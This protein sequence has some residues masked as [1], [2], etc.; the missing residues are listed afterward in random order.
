MKKRR[1]QKRGNQRLAPKKARA[2]RRGPV[3]PNTAVGQTPIATARKLEK[4]GDVAGAVRICETFLASNPR[5]V[6]TLRELASFKFRLESY[7]EAASLLLRAD[8]LDPA[9]PSRLLDL[10][11]TLRLAGRLEEADRFG[12][13]T[14]KAA[15]EN[16]EAHY[17][18]G[19]IRSILG[20]AEEARAAFAACVAADPSHMKARWA[21][22]WN[23][24][25]VYRTSEETD[26]W[27]RRTVDAIDDLT[28]HFD[29]LAA[30]AVE[31]AV[32]AIGTIFLL[33]YHERDDRE[34]Q[35]AYGSLVSRV[36]YA[37][38]GDRALPPE[39]P[40]APRRKRDRI[41]IGYASEHLS[42][43]HTISLLFGGWVL[44]A[45]RDRFEIYV[46]HLGQKVQRNT[47]ILARK[48]DV[49][50]HLNGSVASKIDAIREDD[51]D[52]LVYPDIG[53]AIDSFR[54]A[55]LRLAPVQCVSW[56]HP[57]TTGFPTMDYFLSSD[58]MEPA[59]AEAHYSEQLVRLPNLSI[60]YNPVRAEAASQQEKIGRDRFGIPEE[61][62]AFLCSQAPQKYLPR[63]DDIF[64][65]LAD[66][67]PNCKF[68]FIRNQ[69]AASANERFRDRLYA[70]FQ[71]NGQNPDDY[72][73]FLPWVPWQ[74]FLALNNVCDVFLDS[75][76]WSGGNT[77]LEALA[78]GL[79]AVTLPGGFM[80]GRHTY[81]ML[82]RL[83]AE[84]CIAESVDDYIDIAARL[85][86]DEAFRNRQ[87]DLI[88]SGAR[89]LYHDRSAIE[90][91]EAFYR[92]LFAEPAM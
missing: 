5:N 59:G 75:V 9:D 54:L 40:A 8:R 23:L 6:N 61:A 29:P 86:L 28:A 89:S 62:V 36:M 43:A 48:C 82:K 80:R 21:Q 2:G 39:R 57:V 73:H 46:Y 58:L 10:T 20:D 35:E 45:D 3:T 18:L 66:R 88:R 44:Q 16:A 41:R 70:A 12:R 74:A 14:V 60:Y 15:P 83:G 72:L 76:G 77:T 37:A 4:A 26:L 31:D 90:G 79:P 56:G 65:R 55:A 33:A 32:S 50:R 34:I 11:K 53:M 69:S 22:A 52:V 7:D 71:R 84:D 51:L 85:A 30:G 63:Y 78:Q 13:R 67:V 64:S 87:V 27:R 81:A 68:V 91:L 92:S 24:P 47:E 38:Y 19:Q 42:I 17:E 49:F 1:A 25:R